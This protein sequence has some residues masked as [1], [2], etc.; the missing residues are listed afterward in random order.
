MAYTIPALALAIG[1]LCS[2]VIP[3]FFIDEEDEKVESSDYTLLLTTKA[4][5]VSTSLITAFGIKSKPDQP[6]AEN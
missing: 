4:I 1:A 2:A 6:P 3:T 5:I